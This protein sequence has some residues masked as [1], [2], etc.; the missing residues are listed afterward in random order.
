MELTDLL[1]Q[2]FASQKTFGDKAQMMEYRDGMFQL[3]L[4]D[5]PIRR[6]REAFIQFV[7]RKADLPSPSD[8][9]NL[10]DPLPEPLSPALYVSLQKRPSRSSG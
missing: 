3:I 10:I 9:V 4:A 8:I 2:T 1:S 7:S 5:Y 6:I